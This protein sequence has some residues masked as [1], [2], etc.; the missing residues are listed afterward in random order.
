[1]AIKHKS[2]PELFIDIYKKCEENNKKIK[3]FAQKLDDERIYDFEF[4]DLNLYIKAFEKKIE[5]PKWNKLSISNP[6]ELE[7]PIHGYLVCTENDY[8][9]IMEARWYN[10]TFSSYISDEGYWSEWDNQEVDIY[11]IPIIYPTL[12]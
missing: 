2:W 5:I 8:N 11:W 3:E 1:M 6:D 12:Y 7:I 4:E 10:G 9:M